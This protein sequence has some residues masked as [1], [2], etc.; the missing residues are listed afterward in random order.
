MKNYIVG[1]SFVLSASVLQAQQ[2]WVNVDSVYAPLPAGVQVFFT[3]QKIDT[4]PFRAFYLVADIK[5]NTLDFL[6]DTTYKRRFTPSQFFERNNAPLVVVNGTFFSFQTNQNLN[7]VMNR[8]KLLAHNLP[9]IA[10]RG[11]D[12]MLFHYPLRSA[13]GISKKRMADVARIYTDSA[14]SRAYA[15]PENIVIPA[16]KSGIPSLEFFSS[17][18]D[19][20]KM[21]TAIGGGPILVQSGKV[22]ITNNEEKMFAGKA[23]HDKH[24][25]TAM[26]YT[27]DG[28]LIIMVVEGRNKNAS[29][30]TL[31]QLAALLQE[32]G[33]VEALN[34]DGGGSS[35]LLINGQETIKPSDA[36]GQRAVPAVFMIKTN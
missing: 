10:G 13:I 5:N 23:I 6:T 28:K 29:G 21:K 16:G 12:T 1:L 15:F 20:W 30:A 31:L 2:N 14:T 22:R 32:V 9:S 27:A 3:D 26:G 4:A 33:C 34:L 8:G 11:R 7:L 36:T 18:R 35:C 24:P 19:R 17:Q 25:R